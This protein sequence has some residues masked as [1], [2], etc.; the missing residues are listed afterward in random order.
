MTTADL[1]DQNPPGLQ[2]AEPLFRDYGGRLSF[3]GRVRTVK[4]HEDNSLVRQALEEPGQGAVLVVDGGG[5]LRCAMVGDML[6]ELA[7]RN[8]WSGLVIFGC[9]RDSQALGALEL[10]VKALTTHPQ[11]SQKRNEGQRDIPVRFA[12]VLFEPGQRL[13][14]DPDGVVV[15]SHPREFSIQ[16][17]P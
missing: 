16:A 2:I 14:A 6:G 5:S 8:G 17:E 13:V 10:G 11:K 15:L 3:E 9:V 4:A 12:G 7:V 1:C